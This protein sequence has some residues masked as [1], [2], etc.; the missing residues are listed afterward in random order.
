MKTKFL[1]HF[2]SVPLVALALLTGCKK[3]EAPDEHAGH[4]HAVQDHSGHAHAAESKGT[5]EMCGEHGVPEA[6]CA[7]CQPQLAAALKP[8][9]SLQVRLPSKDSAG[10]VGVQTTTP[11]S[12]AIADAIECVAEVSYNQNK[13][14]QIAAPVGG[15][16]Q[17]VDADLGVQVTEQQCVGRIWSASIGEI[18]GKA[19]L[20]H[21]TLERERKLRAERVTSAQSLQEAEASHRAACQ[22]ARMLGFTEEQID[23]LGNQQN[24]PVY[25]EVRAPFAGEIVERNAVRGSQVEAGKALFT[26]ADRTTM[27]AMLQVPENALALVRAGQ[28]VEL[29]VDSIPGKVFAGKLTW[30]SPAVDERTRLGRARAEFENTDGLLRDRMFATAR[31]LM[32]SAESALLV[33][34][35]AVQHVDGK[36]FVFV[37]READL[38]DVRAVQLG[39]RFAN[40]QELLGGVGAEDQIAVTHAYALKSAMLMSKL[41][42]GCAH[43]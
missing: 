1:S 34:P 10:L 41:G 8:G 18:V 11:E 16:V 15:I 31:I 23:T 40:R 39:A 20:T 27:W 35:A 26:V 38:Y 21:Q 3:Q 2:I 33:P 29:R 32:R 4:D 14:A 25:I 19:V 28:P 43:D 12:G 30:V 7:I 37:K 5:V 36:P 6:L 17:S 22:Q 9:E 13:L 42:A 24:E